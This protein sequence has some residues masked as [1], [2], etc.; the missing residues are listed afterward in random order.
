MKLTETVE[1]KD[2]RQFL[3]FAISDQEMGFNIEC[4]REVLKPQGIHS[5]VNAPDFIE[6]II[7]VR[8]YALVVISLRKRFGLKSLESG[9]KERIIICKVNNMIVGFIVDSVS[10]VLTVPL[11]DIQ[12]PPQVLSLQNQGQYVCGLI[13]VG[14][15][16]VTL[17]DLEKIVTGEELARLSEIKA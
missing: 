4:V 15:R 9:H 1:K 7:Y 2:D 5:L 6:G 13:K 12:P 3:V 17:L 16:L 10:E 14:E 8:K 11:K